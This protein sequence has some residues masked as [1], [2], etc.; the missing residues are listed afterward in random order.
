MKK[1]FVVKFYIYASNEDEITRAQEAAS[2]FV[3][4]QYTRGRLVTAAKLAAA[5]ETAKNN[6]FISNLLT[7]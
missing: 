6:P 5:L 1:P 2:E 4:H 7:E 3:R